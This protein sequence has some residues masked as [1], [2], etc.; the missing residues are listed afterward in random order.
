M[1]LRLVAQ[2]VL[3]PDDDALRHRYADLA[4]LLAL[5]RLRTLDLTNQGVTDADLS[6]LAASPHVAG[7]RFLDLTQN[8]ITSQGLDALAA[9]RALPSL[10]TVGLQ[11]N[12]VHDPVDQLEFYDETNQHRVPTEE[13]R[14][15][16][17][18]YGR[19][20]WLHPD[21]PH[22]PPRRLPLP[23]ATTTRGA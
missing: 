11:L 21:D 1:E 18:K 22:L 6:A 14:A 23:L 3:Y 7:L 16:E 5:A 17:Q 20:P 15:L 9:S 2:I 12:R 19:L 13:G 4:A 10:V 8:E